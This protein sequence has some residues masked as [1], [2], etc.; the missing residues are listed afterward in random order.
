M[1]NRK[2]FI[3]NYK[4]ILS[5]LLIL[6]ICFILMSR[7][8]V[9]W[10]NSAYAA[11][12]GVGLVF[13]AILNFI[14]IKVKQKNADYEEE[15]EMQMQDERVILNQMKALAYAG[16]VAIASLVFTNTLAAIMDFDL[17]VGNIVVLFS[18]SISLA[19]FKWFYRNK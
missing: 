18:Y 3:K 14:V 9:K 12:L 5:T 13:A 10:I 2:G 7:L 1:I 6:G 17:A 11:G 4:M 16:I 19:G 8:E 15:V